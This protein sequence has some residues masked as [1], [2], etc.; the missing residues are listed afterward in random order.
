MKS[1]K[2]IAESVLFPQ[3]LGNKDDGLSELIGKS[4][5]STRKEKVDDFRKDNK[6][7]K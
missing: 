4:I 6:L 3:D 1:L 5:E 2:Q 7:V